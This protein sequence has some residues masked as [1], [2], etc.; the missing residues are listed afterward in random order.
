MPR[1]P[2]S[3]N[4]PQVRQRS[5][6]GV[7][8]P[9]A[10]RP[11]P[12]QAFETGIGQAAEEFAPALD[13]LAEAAQ[14]ERTRQ[15]T[16]AAAGAIGT[17]M[18]EATSARRSLETEADLADPGVG[19]Q[20]GRRLEQRKQ[21]LLQSFQGDPETAARLAAR[22]QG[23]Q[24]QQALALG[25]QIASAQRARVTGLLGDQI[26]SFTAAA[27]ENP[28][29]VPELFAS[30]DGVVQDMAPALT[31]EQ[32][33]EFTDAGRQQITLSAVNTLLA[34]GD[35]AGA[36]AILEIPGVPEMLTPQQ[37]QT[38]AQTFEQ[39]EARRTAA[40]REAQERLTVAETLLGRDLTAAERVQLAG[41]AAPS[42]ERTLAAKVR[43]VEAVL[44]RP[45]T[46]AERARLAGLE[47]EGART[48][49]GK[50]IEDREHF[51][52]TFGEGSPQVQAFDELTSKQDEP[53]DLSD[54]AGLRKE[55]TRA[56]QDFV[57][58]RDAFQRIEA[59]AAEPSAAGDVA[60][61]FNFMK[62][63]DP[64][65]VVREG[66]FATARNAAGVPERV[67]NTFNRL[68]SGE[69]LTPEQRADFV[70][71]ARNLARVMLRS[72]RR[73]EQQFAAIA[74]RSGLPP[75]DVVVDFTSGLSIGAGEGE[76]PTIRITGESAPEEQGPVIEYD[77]RGRRIK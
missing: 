54:V 38:I 2:S 65:S 28:S 56:S 47:P 10:P 23:I 11:A 26:K 44:G 3:A 61:V 40:V 66:E 64:G 25:E 5:D 59:S 21:E 27:I 75:E 29:G 48:E 34:R 14:R 72:Q 12:A 24:T 19:V 74:E 32:E 73:L 68:L 67:R 9:G 20:F 58:V 37:Q 55:F 76:V 49:A 43:E 15:A 50:L 41:F 51:V 69:Q 57:Q 46:E 1:L 30:F 17:F 77:L 71:Q 8:I 35:V 22:L 70:Q 60:L 4:V 63:L 7:R 45:T 16:V 39:A 42:G 31:P 52:S 6:P 62:A 33:S 13:R 53:P 18:E 36:R